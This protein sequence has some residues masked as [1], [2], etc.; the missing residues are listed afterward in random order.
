M[1]TQTKRKHDNT[2]ANAT[3]IHT[4]L[5]DATN[6]PNGIGAGHRIDISVTNSTLIVALLI[7]YI[8]SQPFNIIS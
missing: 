2:N 4:S 7:S 6:V 5:H 8:C 1:Q 3:T